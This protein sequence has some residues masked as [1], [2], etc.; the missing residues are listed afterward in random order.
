MITD[1]NIEDF[2][3]YVHKDVIKNNDGSE[4]YSFSYMKGRKYVRIVKTYMN[5]VSRS[6]YCFID[7][8]TGDILKSAGWKG[9]AEGV[10]GNIFKKEEM[11]FDAYGECFYRDGV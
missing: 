2:L 3:D 4:K 5:N 10:R 11:K 8:N 6:S 1:Q 7:M 9:P